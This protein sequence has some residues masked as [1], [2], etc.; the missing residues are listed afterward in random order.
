MISLA[1][2]ARPWPGTTCWAATFQKLSEHTWLLILTP[3]FTLAGNAWSPFLRFTGGR[4]VGVWAGGIIGISPSLFLGA[5]LAYLCAWLATRRSAES[6]LAV[7]ILLPFAGLFW[8][9][10]WLLIGVPQQFAVYAAAAAVIILLK[11]LASN[12]GPLPA[13]LSAPSQ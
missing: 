9:E 1:A 8:P 13:D 2:P 7:L 11:R 3:L 10:G 4:G 6:L 5:L 12:G